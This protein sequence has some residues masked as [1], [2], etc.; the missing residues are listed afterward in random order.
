MAKIVRVTQN[1][2]GDLGPSGDFG[3]FGSKANPPQTFSMDPTQIQSLTAF[4]QGWGASIIGNYE[5]PLEDMNSLF[6]LAFRQICYMF[7]E[8]ISEYD[9]GTTYFTGSI[10]KENGVVYNSLVDNNVGNDP[11]SDSGTNWQIGFGGLSGAVPTG[12]VLPWGGLI[13]SIP[14]GYI[15]CNGAAISRTTYSRL[16]TAVGSQYGNG[17]GTTTFNIPDGRGR[18]LVGVDSTPEFPNIGEVGGERKHQLTIPEMPI[19]THPITTYGFLSVVSGSTTPAWLNTSG[20]N[21]G[22]TG[23]DTP[24]NNLQPY[25]VIG[26]SIIKI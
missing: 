20:S 12:A 6:L 23:G 2:F 15:F 4:R 1:Q 14:A 22:A 25:L 13:T 3:I 18:I 17:D 8:G 11:A 24:H 19:H 9:S 26:G 10:V 16:F 7:Q 5:P 21:T